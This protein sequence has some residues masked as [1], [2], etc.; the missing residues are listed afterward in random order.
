M[1]KALIPAPSSEQDT[2][3]HFPSQGNSLPDDSI[4]LE[5]ISLPLRASSGCTCKS[6]KGESS[7]YLYYRLG[8]RTVY[9]SYLINELQQAGLI[10]DEIKNKEHNW[11]LVGDVD[12]ISDQ[13][14]NRPTN[15]ASLTV[16]LGIH[17]HRQTSSPSFFIEITQQL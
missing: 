9:L 6:T 15:M 8:I 7:Y 14:I 1:I 17:R 12:R 5:S 4:A 16:Y 11:F 10:I 2:Y 3:Q 13:P